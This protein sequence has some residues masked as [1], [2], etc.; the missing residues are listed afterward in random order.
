MTLPPPPDDNLDRLLADHLGRQASRLEV[1]P[2]LG[3]IR[4]TVR[5]NPPNPA[6]ESRWRRLAGWALPVAIAAGVAAVLFFPPHAEPLRASPQALLQEA[7]KAHH[8]PLDRCYLVEFQRTDDGA[9]ENPLAGQFRTTRLWTRGDRFWIESTNPRAR[10]AWGR[11]EDGTIWIAPGPRRGVRVE[12][13]EAPR[14]L[15]HMCDI[16]ELRPEHLLGELLRDFDLVREDGPTPATQVIRATRKPG[17][18]APPLRSAVLELDTETKALRRVVLD[19]VGPLRSV[20]TTYTLVETQTLADDR[21]R[22]EGH[23]VAPF[24]IYTADNQPQLRRQI[25]GVVFGPRAADWF[26]PKEG[27]K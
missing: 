14:W 27:S 16:S 2:L 9:D 23:L 17:R 24:E 25:L 3:R 7:Q 15:T 1:G 26:K 22:L 8:L 11:G 13:D 6:R 4:T 5:Q 20:T 10:W 19:R 18:W 12:P 21:Y